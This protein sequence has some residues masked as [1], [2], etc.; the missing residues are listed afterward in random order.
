MPPEVIGLVLALGVVAGIGLMIGM[1]IAMRR[2]V[3]PLSRR[4]RWALLLMLAVA[5]GGAWAAYA[6]VRSV[7]DR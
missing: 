5:G 2:E 6:L 4:A 1:R 7:L 3:E